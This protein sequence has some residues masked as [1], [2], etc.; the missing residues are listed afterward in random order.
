MQT[1]ARFDNELDLCFEAAD[2]RIGLIQMALRLMHAIA[3]AVM[4][5]T[6]VLKFGFDVTQF[7][8]LFFQIDLRFFDVAEMFVLLAFGF[9]FAQ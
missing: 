1:A 5:L 2:F 4:R 8:S 3:G 6:H 7:G 9:V